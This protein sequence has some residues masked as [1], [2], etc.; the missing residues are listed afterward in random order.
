MLRQ[1]KRPRAMLVLAGLALTAAAW[2]GGC[3]LAGPPAPPLP[4]ARESSP[5]GF[6][7][8]QGLEGRV[9]F[10]E[11]GLVGCALSDSGLDAMIAMNRG[12]EIKGLAYLR[13]EQAKD[14]QAAARYAAA[15]APGFP[16]IHDPEAAVARAFKATVYP[17]FLLVDKYGHVR[18]RG[19][20]P[21]PAQ[22]DDWA[23]TLGRE[24]SDPGPQAPLFGVASLD[25]PKL[26]AETK[27]PDLAGA[28]KPLGEYKGKGGLVAVFVDT[29]CPFSGEAIGDMPKVIAAVAKHD[30][31]TLLVNLADPAATVKEFYAKRTAAGPLVFDTT[32]AT[33]AAWKIDSVPTVFLFDASGNVIYRGKAVWKDVATAAESM[34][35]L[36]AGSL[37]IGAAGTEFG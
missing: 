16:V 20:M 12:N 21:D 26:L 11:F 25:V 1:A 22:L 37:K 13:V 36:T 2:A 3:A 33:Q 19:P 18:Y 34:L 24:A 4:V 28:V 32:K 9:A 23:D 15:K 10:I 27:L 5:A 14:P 31:P 17:T 6:L 29:T 8:E 30:V 7:K 35:K